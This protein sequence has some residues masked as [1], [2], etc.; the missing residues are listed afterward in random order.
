MKEL[1]KAL[2]E[3]Q[4]NMDK[5]V[6]DKKNPHF[7]S[8][9]ASLSNVIG[10]ARQPLADAGIAVFETTEVLEEAILQTMLLV[11]GE[12]GETMYSAFPLRAKDPSNPQQLGSAQTYARRYLWTA[13]A[14]LA[15]E[16]DDGNS[17]S[18]PKPK[19]PPKPKKT[20]DVTMWELADEFEAIGRA[21]EFMAILTDN[22]YK[23]I[24]DVKD[25]D[26]QKTIYSLAK[27]KLKL[28]KEAK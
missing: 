11:H 15:P 8:N 1:A 18:A 13:I 28:Y 7:N 6:K 20:F 14:G 25:K 3:A 9:F 21:K 26:E 12:S 17:A 16:D 19:A 4:S 24:E 2:I 23:V 10:V 27:S 5:L 22:N